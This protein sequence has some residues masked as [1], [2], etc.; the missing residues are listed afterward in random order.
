LKEIFEPVDIGGLKLRNR[1]VRS[2]TWEA[3]A[4]P[5]GSIDA[6]TYEVYDELARGGIGLVITGFTSV[7]GNDRYFGGMMRL[8]DDS[9]IPQ[10]ARLVDAIHAH[11]VPVL[12]QL[13]LGA[14][15]RGDGSQAEPSFMTEDG[16]RLVE[17]RFVDAAVRAW[18]AG[19]DGVQV[20]VAHFFFLSRFVSPAVNHRSDEC[21]GSTEN[22]TRIV[23][24]I[25]R[26]IREVASRV[27]S[28]VLTPWGVVTR[29]SESSRSRRS[30][31]GSITHFRKLSTD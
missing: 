6:R 24:D 22:R 23:C 31:M 4:A 14:F 10:Y 25:V 5:D 17:R 3:L 8:H 11:G 19:F 16:I 15:Y 27:Y 18:K 13:A 26:G 1:L 21:G 12:A 30:V 29:P 2:A 9:L 20:H 28:P 7:A